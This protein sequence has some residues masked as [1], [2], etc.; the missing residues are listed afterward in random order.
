LPTFRGKGIEANLLEKA[1]QE[2]FK[3]S[4]IVGIGVGLYRDY[5]PAQCL[6]ISRGYKPDGRGVTYHDEPVEPGTNVRL[7]YDLVLWFIKS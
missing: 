6:N 7:D 5:G 1:E 3:R 2:A 4:E